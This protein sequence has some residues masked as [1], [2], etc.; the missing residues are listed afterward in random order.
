MNHK[1]SALIGNVVLWGISGLGTIFFLMIMFGQDVGIDGGLYLTYLAF[2]LGIVLAL[3]SGVMTLVHSA[4]I[5]STLMP[6]GAFIVLF[7]V[8]YL[9]ADGAVKPSWGISESA[10]KMIG[11]GLIMTALAALIAVVAAI[12]GAVAKF[13]K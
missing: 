1:S 10:S 6:L 3:A 11:A 12:Y 8:S 2:G 7:G 4:N 13:F 5:K 9:L